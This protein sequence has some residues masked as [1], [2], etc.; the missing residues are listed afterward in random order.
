MGRRWGKTY[1]AGVYALTSADFGGAVAWVVPTYKN[2]RAPWRF[3]EAM[4]APLG[5]S[6]RVNRTD[7]MI[8]FPGGGRL[9][10]YSADSDVALR[11][12]AF[13]LVIVDEAAQVREETFSDVLLP[14]IADRDGRMVLISTPKGRNWFWREWIRGQNDGKDAASWTA[15]TMANPMPTIQAAARM[16]KERVSERTYKQEWLA[17][18]LADGGS[19]IRFVRDAVRPMPDGPQPNR[20]YIGGLDWA[21]SNDYTWLALVDAETGENV[22]NDRFTGIDYRLQR[23]RIMATCKRWNVAVVNAESNA[24]GKPNNDELRAADMPV[25]DFVTTN[26]TK[27]DIIE[28]LAAAFENHRITIP[29]DPVLIAELESLEATRLQ[30]GAVRYAAPDGMHDDGSMALALA[31]H[32]IVGTGPL[33]W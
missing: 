27:A 18:F 1:M 28:S 12:E 10:I 22:Y 19:V 2:A 30:S 20:T 15:P 5:R 9:S 8:E 21:L 25:R 24:M 3:A 17:E 16:A 31:W 7:R 23:E 32:G 13:D 29:D 33:I 6:V 14:T 4:V 26:T 11:G